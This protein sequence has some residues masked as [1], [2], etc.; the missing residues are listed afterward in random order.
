MKK[1]E[2]KLLTTLKKGATVVCACS[3]GPDSMALLSVINNIREKLNLKVI[4]AH[5]NHKVRK[6]S[7]DEAKLVEKYAIDNNDIFEL[8]EITKYHEKTNFHEDARIIRYKFLEDVVNKYNAD[9]LMTAH[10][11]DDLIETILM[12]ISRGSNLKGY[13]GFKYINNW[14]KIK[15]IRPLVFKTKEELEN[16]N[17][18]NNIPYVIDNSNYSELYTRNR[19]RHNILPLLKYED[20]NI[21]LKY[22]QFSMEL[23]KY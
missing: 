9:Y 4:C 5:V 6:E 11:G 15:L 13:I 10:H 1:V 18:E 3:G 2:T 22:L 21:H 23:N 8:F 20:K 19:Y 14:N 12:R 16:Y 7:D 17:K